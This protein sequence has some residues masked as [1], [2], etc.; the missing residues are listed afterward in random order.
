MPPWHRKEIKTSDISKGVL[1]FNEWF[2]AMERL[3]AKDYK[4]LMIAIY[5][6][7]INNIPPP[8]FTGRTKMVATIIFPCIERRKSQSERGLASA[9]ARLA[10]KKQ[11]NTDTSNSVANSVANGVANGVANQSKEKKNRIE[12]SY[13]KAE[14]READ[15]PAAKGE[16]SFDTND[17]FE[18]AVRRSLGE[19]SE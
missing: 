17:F 16:A 9:A 13:N 5:N 6:A 2:D 3:S 10:R 12:Y 1:I 15:A 8:E 7:Q 18:A 4:A 14:R 11:I 19:A